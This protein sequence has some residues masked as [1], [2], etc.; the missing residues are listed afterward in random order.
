MGR[1][2]N[3]VI[4]GIVVFALLALGGAF[5]YTYEQGK[6]IGKADCQLAIQTASEEAEQRVRDEWEAA[7]AQS[8]EVANDAVETDNSIEDAKDDVIGDI[9]DAALEKENVECFDSDDLDIFN[10]L[11]SLEQFKEMKDEESK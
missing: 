8:T 11:R 3:K 9:I 10:S 6:A 1:K 7:S 4:I 2:M 5:K